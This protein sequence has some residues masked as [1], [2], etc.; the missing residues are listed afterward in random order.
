MR[1]FF[2]D[3]NNTHLVG[4]PILIDRMMNIILDKN[5]DKYA[6]EYGTKPVKTQIRLYANFSKGDD[7][8]SYGRFRFLEVT[9]SINKEFFQREPKAKKSFKY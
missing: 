7:N 3:E 9:K 8:H 2:N 4:I 1:R 5:G 6:N